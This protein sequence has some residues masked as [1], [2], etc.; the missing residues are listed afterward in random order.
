MNRL[1]HDWSHW[2]SV[3]AVLRHGSLSHAARALGLTQPTIG[4]H[5]D[6]IEAALGA[7]LFTRT[8]TGLSPTPVALALIPYAEAMEASAEAL[9]RTAS[10]E[11]DKERG[12]VRVTASEIVGSE[13]L[14]P[15]LQ[16]F[17]A[18]YPGIAIELDLSDVQ[19]DMLER[20]AD[21]AV[22]MVRPSQGALVGKKVAT[23]ELRLFAHEDYA[24]RR[25]LPSSVAEL[26]EHDLIGPDRN[27][28]ILG[29][30]ALDGRVLTQD[31]FS[32]R[33]D[34]EVAR[35]AA[36]R[37]GLGIGIC[38]SAIARTEL[39]LVPVLHDKVA[40]AM[41]MWLVMHEALKG[42]KRVRL[43]YDYLSKAF[44]AHYGAPADAPRT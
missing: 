26:F 36:L 5:I 15:I 14:P 44:V 12:V 2:R 20:D 28:A 17:R 19:A 34:S 16:R 6:G 1:P 21:I 22:R 9:R 4:R 7:S 38:Q 42:I 24:K 10:G 31:S 32:F 29:N 40:F 30:Y 13:C 37:A 25:P 43:L 11:I 39:D 41:E 3:A 33:C 27:T 35:I 23:V 8:R 18:A